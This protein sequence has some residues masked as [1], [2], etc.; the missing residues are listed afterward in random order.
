VKHIVD[1]LKAQS[2]WE[3]TIFVFSTGVIRHSPWAV[4]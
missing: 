2:M 1:E 4:E 3:K